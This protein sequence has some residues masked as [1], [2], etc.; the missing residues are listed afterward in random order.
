[1]WKIA[2]RHRVVKVESGE[3]RVQTNKDMT[4][5]DEKLWKYED[6]IFAT[7]PEAVL[8]LI[9]LWKEYR[10]QIRENMLKIQREEIAE[11]VSWNRI[12]NDYYDKFKDVLQDDA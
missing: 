2:K 11:K 4:P 8:F 10:N 7:E 5:D 1:M 6:A 3:Y 9:K 12:M